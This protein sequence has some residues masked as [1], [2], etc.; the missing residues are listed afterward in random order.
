[1]RAPWGG[2]GGGG[3]R[4][5][6]ESWVCRG[7]SEGGYR[8]ER[9]G[10]GTKGGRGGFSR[11]GGGSRM[12]LSL[13]KEDNQTNVDVFSCNRE[14]QANS[15]N[16]TAAQTEKITQHCK[17]YRHWQVGKVYQLG[18]PPDMKLSVTWRASAVSGD[19]CWHSSH[20]RGFS[21][22]FAHSLCHCSLHI[23]A[24]EAGMQHYIKET[25]NSS[26]RRKEEEEDFTSYSHRKNKEI[27]ATVG[28]HYMHYQG[29]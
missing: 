12:G 24:A 6:V 22:R 7:Y 1:M 15:F 10:E 3:A 27:K 13:L 8:A 2:G 14:P 26:R 4:S 29:R 16:P 21:K 20:K 28:Q 25:N 19:A 17:V 23:S 11:R 18:A 9:E 5:G